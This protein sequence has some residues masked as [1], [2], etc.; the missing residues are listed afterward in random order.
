MKHVADL[1]TLIVAQ[2]ISV[3]EITSTRISCIA[4]H[5]RI[6][7]TNSEH[8]NIVRFILDYLVV[9]RY[10]YIDCLQ[11][12]GPSFQ[13]FQA[14][15][16]LRQITTSWSSRSRNFNIRLYESYDDSGAGVCSLKKFEPD[17]RTA[18]VYVKFVSL[19]TKSKGCKLKRVLLLHRS[20]FHFVIYYHL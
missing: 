17:Y 10:I 13:T 2:K 8:L 7:T 18:D 15:S 11:I 6:V 9:S 16:T 14:E 19:R 5:S 1:I 12:A 20:L 4:G 3:S